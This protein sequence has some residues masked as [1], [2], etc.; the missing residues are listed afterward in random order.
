MAARWFASLRGQLGGIGRLFV[1]LVVL[2]CCVVSEAADNDPSEGLI[3]LNPQKTLFLDRAGKRVLL[4]SEVCLREGLLEMLVCL[5]QTKEH[6]A[7]LAYQGQ[8]QTVHAGL[9]ALGLE[10]GRTVRFQPTYLPATGAELEI[11]LLWTTPDGKSHAA[12]A[13]SWVRNATRRYFTE[14]LP[15][16]P[17]TLRL[18][19]EDE[20]RYDERHGELL[21]YGQ[22]TAEKRDYWKG[23]SQ[24]ADW[25]KAIERF[26]Q[27]T[28]FQELKAAFVFA[29][30]QFYSNPQTGQ[31][32][33]EAE[34]GDL[35]CVANFPS[36]AIDLAIPS[37]S[38]N[39]DLSY[40]AWTE[41][42]PPIGTV[43]W[44]ELKPAPVSQQVPADALRPENR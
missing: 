24:Q 16:L 44:V 21:W 7:I 23:R 14:K 39:D 3:S 18:T 33:Y 34:A 42:I 32:F 15:A 40:E 13:Q 36:A 41:R 4:K 43:V 17:N 29:G 19:R 35:I 11:R 20:L 2:D 30:S 9:L 38:Q 31:Q 28:R 5:K 1:C 22:M 12:K 8:A 6:E 26:Y 25:R 10:P 27:R 37:S